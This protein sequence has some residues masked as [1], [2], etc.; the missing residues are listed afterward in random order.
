MAHLES[1]KHISPDSGFP[2]TLHPKF[3]DKIKD[4]IPPDPPHQE[5]VPA[6]DRGLFADPEKKA[7][8]STG[9]TRTD[10]TE[11]IG[12]VLD[13]IQLSQLTPQQLD[14]LALLANERGVVFFRDQDLTTESQIRIIFEHY[15]E[16]DR[17]PSQ[18]DTK[19][20]V[21]R[22]STQDHREILKYTPWPSG[23]FHADTLV[24]DQPAELFDAAHGGGTRKSAGTWPECLHTA[25]GRSQPRA[26]RHAPPGRADAPR[27]GAQGPSTSTPASSRA[28]GELKKVRVGQAARLF[29][30]A[31]STSRPTITRSGGSG[32]SGPWPSGTTGATVHRVIPGSYKAPRRGIRTTVFGEKPYYDP[33]S[34][35]R[36]ERAERAESA[37][38]LNGSSWKSPR[39]VKEEE[40]GILPA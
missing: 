19:H 22:G 8:F 9:A 37:E 29:S 35:G 20:H 18:K 38:N 31:T 32:T 1:R 21:I 33:A 25:W 6:K 26:R 4:H 24:R 16:L 14:G 2:I 13:D 11:P 15:G 7:L 27:D 28:F 10:L 39:E 23:D 3:N 36:A 12:T 17:H 30:A 5:R 40:D 34:E